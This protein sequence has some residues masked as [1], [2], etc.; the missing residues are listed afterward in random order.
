M[1]LEKDKK[2]VLKHKINLSITNNHLCLSVFLYVW[3]LG[4]HLAICISFT[5]V[6][7]I[8]EIKR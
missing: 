6:L 2:N 3:A 7:A 4:S 1:A 5:H 8:S